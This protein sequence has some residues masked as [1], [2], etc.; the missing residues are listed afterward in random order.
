MP[1]NFDRLIERRNTH[2]TKWDAY[3]SD[4]MPLWVADMDFATPEPIL[5]ALRQKVEHGIFGY[6]RASKELLATVASRMQ[7]LYNW[8]VTPDMVV[9]IPGVISGFNLAARVTCRPGE[10]ILIQPPVY[11][12]FLKVHENL[13]LTH[14]MAPLRK[15]NSGNM[16]HYEVDLDQFEV[17]LNTSGAA[18][19]MFLLCQPHNPSGAIY[20]PEQM[21]RLA[22][23]C[24][25]H[26]IT[27]CS[28]EIHSE[29]LLGGANFT[30]MAVLSPE[31]A[32]RTITLVSP[33]KTFNVAG[34]YC[35]FA[36]IP[37]PDLCQAYRQ[38]LD[39]TS[40]HLSSP[41]LAAAQVAFSGECDAWLAELLPYLTANRDALVAYVH[42]NLPGVGYFLPDATYLAWLDF[43]E[44][45][46]N[47]K[48]PASPYKFFLKEARLA[49]ND[50]ETFGPGG[51]GF[52]RLNFG[53]PRT[54]LM[55]A[56]ERMKTALDA[57]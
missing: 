23:I 34:L 14:Q 19:R 22:E 20:T 13:G 24:L 16:L 44:L 57:N 31:I 17:S 36:I 9:A 26:G 3:P 43:N 5:E 56:L 10:G 54:T 4:V 32:D 11:P 53:C 45:I 35:A 27:I 30:P 51:N 55:T 7:K 39:R 47:G 2:S 12:P 33:S 6:E 8:Q 38:E 18:T 29:L 25:D 1:T 46:K 40:M 50:G 15:V 49:L 37:N 28:D 21:M 42:Q 41:G 52:V 48:M